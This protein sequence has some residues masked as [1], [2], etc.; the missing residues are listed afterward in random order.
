MKAIFLADAHLRDPDDPAWRDLLAF[1]DQLPADLDRLFI[2]GDFFDFWYGYPDRAFP[3]YRPL[4]ES[5]A[6]LTERGIELIFFAGNHELAPGPLLARLGSCSEDHLLIRLDESRLYLCHGDRLDPD[7]HGYRLWRRLI[8]S[9]TLGRLIEKVPA[10]L[11]WKIA[12]RLSAGSRGIN[13]SCRPIP[14]GVYRSIYRILARGPVDSLVC[15]HF[16][17]SRRETFVTPQG[18]KNAWFVGAWEKDRSWLEYADGQ[19]TPRRF[20]P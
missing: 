17:Q 11:T 6:R 4:L 14:P 13:G 8:R 16:H 20:Q 12:A 5:L 3:V 19:F 18:P 7:D 1:F 2:L 9:R 15:G 10:A